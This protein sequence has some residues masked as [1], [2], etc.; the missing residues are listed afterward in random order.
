MLDFWSFEGFIGQEIFYGLFEGFIAEHW[1]PP[2]EWELTQAQEA[3]NGAAS[4]V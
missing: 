2:G 3:A 4:F 1:E